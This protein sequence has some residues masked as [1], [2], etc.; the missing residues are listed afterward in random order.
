M[1]Q[2][3]SCRSDLRGLAL[4]CEK[5]QRRVAASIGGAM[6][7]EAETGTMGRGCQ[8]LMVEA[9]LVM[10]FLVCATEERKFWRRV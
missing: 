5:L 8:V 6:S 7:A 3:T 4:W 2:V 9:S 1:V 10:V